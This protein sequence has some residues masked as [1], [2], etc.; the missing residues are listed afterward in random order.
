MQKPESSNQGGEIIYPEG[1]TAVDIELINKQCELQRAT[2]SEQIQ[3][4]SQAYSEAKRLALNQTELAALTGETVENFILHLASFIE[5]RNEN[6]YRHVPVTFARGGTAL[7]PEVVPRAMESFSEAYAESRLTPTE[8]Y[9]EFEKIHPLEDG[10]GRLGDLLW[11]I[12]ITRETGRWPELLPP[13]IFGS[14]YESV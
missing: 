13:D 10:N 14:N 4:F 9:T 8:A 3:G 6:G 7:A 1:L 2:S 5:K 11:K 12:A